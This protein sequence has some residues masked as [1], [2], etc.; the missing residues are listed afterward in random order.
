MLSLSCGYIIAERDIEQIHGRRCLKDLHQS[1]ALVSTG[2]SSG[3]E[4]ARC[5][6]KSCI[7]RALNPQERE[8]GQGGSDWLI[9]ENVR[10]YMFE[11]VCVDGEIFHT[12]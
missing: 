5:C 1:K 4:I 6:K 9:F 8:H 10:K 11:V 2:M 7:N 3:L 12:Y